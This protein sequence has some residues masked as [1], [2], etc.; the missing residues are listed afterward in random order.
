MAK[1][2][3]IKAPTMAELANKHEL[4]QQA[5]QCTEFEIEFYED[6]FRDLRGKR[7]KPMTMREDFCGT[8]MFAVDW[9]KSNPKRQ[10]IGVDLCS[11]TLRWGLENIIEPAGASVNRRV[12]LLNDNV[13]SVVTEKVDFTCAMNFSYGVF[14]TRELLR[15]YFKNVLKSLK[16][17]GL[18]FLDLMGGTTTI[19]VNEEYKYLAQSE[20][21]YIWEHESYNPINHDI[22]CHIHFEFEDGSRMDKAFTYEWR[23]W[24]LP[25]LHELLLEAGF[26]SVHFFWEEFIEDNDPKNDYMEATGNYREVTCVDQQESWL[27]YIVAAV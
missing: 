14:K 23:L 11:D 1:R 22:K 4:Y 19:D 3:R 21:M 18:F 10:A 27:A 25:E 12:T 8:A 24:S 20:V 13:L 15:D 7:R 9:C 17:D 26:S 5:V 2:K 16:D 6:R